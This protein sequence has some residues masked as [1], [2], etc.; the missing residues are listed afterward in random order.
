MQNSVGNI[1]T[2]RT[3]GLVNIWQLLRKLYWEMEILAAVP[4]KYFPQEKSS[5]FNFKD[6]KSYAAINVASTNLSLIDWLFHRLD[7]DELLKQAFKNI[8]PLVT[9]DGM[10]RFSES[11]RNEK[12]ELQVCHQIC[13][14]NKHYKLHGGLDVTISAK[15]IDLVRVDNIDETKVLDIITMHNFF[16]CRPCSLGDAENK[17]LTPNEAFSETLKW[18]TFLFKA[19]SIPDQIIYFPELDAWQNQLPNI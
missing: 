15:T 18:W 11:L 19:I 9:L 5:I 6:A 12:L 4:E 1:A 17:R 10:K 3:L 16:I 13:N 7:N 14:S 8:H 2:D